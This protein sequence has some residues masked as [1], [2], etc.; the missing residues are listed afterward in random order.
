MHA[1]KPK[2][3]HSW[4]EFATEIAVIVIG[5]LIALSLEQMVEN[6]HERKLY[7]EAREAM[8]DELN[9]DVSNISRR[10][11]FEPCIRQRLQDIASLLDRAENHE[12]FDAPSWIGDAA[13][14]RIRFTAE[15]EAGR[16]NLFTSKEQ[17]TFGRLYAYLHSVDVEQDR[18]RLAW[19]RLQMLEGRGSLSPEMIFGAR[20]A[21]ADA[22]F[23]HDRI[24]LLLRFVNVI[25]QQ[26]EVHGDVDIFKAAN[27]RFEPDAW[28]HCL[29]MNT[30]KEKAEKLSYILPNP[31]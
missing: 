30:P 14:L 7:R 12:P 25:A 24:Q 8:H 29:P 20:A 13:S 2:P 11:K 5:I 28:A 18:E 16:S 27:V 17:A 23:E 1:H 21:L 10:E 9:Y 4:R 15:S 26:A 19:A 6:W 3:V 31:S 22:R